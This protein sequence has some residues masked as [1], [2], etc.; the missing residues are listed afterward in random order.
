MFSLDFSFY[1]LTS[2][3]SFSNHQLIITFSFGSH[4][5]LHRGL[6]VAFDKEGQLHNVLN[7][8]VKLG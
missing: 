8:V 6:V 3:P 2:T 1:N 5:H 7:F 4:L